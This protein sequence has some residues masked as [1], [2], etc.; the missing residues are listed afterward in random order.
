MLQQEHPESLV[1]SLVLSEIEMAYLRTERKA[2]GHACMFGGVVEKN[3]VVK[4]FQRAAR[5]ETNWIFSCV[6]CMLLSFSEF[7]LL[8]L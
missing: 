4:V 7:S 5:R 1:S 8:C 2:S 3:C 6:L